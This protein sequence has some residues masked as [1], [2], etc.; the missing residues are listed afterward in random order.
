VLATPFANFSIEIFQTIKI[1]LKLNTGFHQQENLASDPAL[2]NNN[3]SIKTAD[4]RHFEIHV[5][6]CSSV[7]VGNI[8]KTFVMD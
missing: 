7:A 1:D 4:S 2:S 6:C 5:Y 8:W 3:N